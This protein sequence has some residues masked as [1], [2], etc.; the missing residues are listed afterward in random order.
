MINQLDTCKV[1]EDK[2]FHLYVELHDENTL[3]IH[4]NGIY[5]IWKNRVQ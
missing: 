5:P 2:I 4:M 1:E 3:Q